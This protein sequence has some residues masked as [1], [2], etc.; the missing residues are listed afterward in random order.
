MT[1][2]KPIKYRPYIKM[3]TRSFI[4]EKVKLQLS[5][6]VQAYAVFIIPIVVKYLNIGIGIGV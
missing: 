1:V 6:R 5:E 3:S 2:L 4:E